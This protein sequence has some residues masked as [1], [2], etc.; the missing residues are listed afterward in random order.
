MRIIIEFQSEY[1]EYIPESG[2]CPE[3][4]NAHKGHLC[5]TRC[6][7]RGSQSLCSEL[8]EIDGYFKRIKR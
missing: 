2:S 3:D 6:E 5:K 4:C 8:G 7:D 1:Y